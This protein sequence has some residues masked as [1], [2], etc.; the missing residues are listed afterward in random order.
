M[1]E[2]LKQAVKI[3]V[4]ADA[5][6]KVIR[7]TLCRAAERTGLTCT[8]VANHTVPV[9]KRDNIHSL[10]VPAGFDIADNE[11]VKRVNAGDLVITSDI[12]LAD[13][14]ITKNAVALSP[15]GELYTKDTIKARLNIRDFMDTMR[16]SG[17]Q[18]GGP[19]P[20]GQTERREFANHLDRFLARATR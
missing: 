16:S 6:P 10:T 7:E 8:F 20:L 4:D 11:I 9:P 3:W 18:T 12:P 15:R 13:E 14:V 5:C 1:T 2:P 19:A 17:V